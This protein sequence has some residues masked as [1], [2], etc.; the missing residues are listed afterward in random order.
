MVPEPTLR[1]EFPAPEESIISEIE[2]EGFRPSNPLITDLSTLLLIQ[3]VPLE[4]TSLERQFIRRVVMEANIATFLGS[5][6]TPFATTMGGGIVPRPPPSPIRSIAIPTPMT[7]G[8]GSVP[9]IVPTIVLFTQNVTD[10]PF[11]YGM[12]E[13]DTNSV[14]TYSTLQTMGL[15]VGISKSPLQGST[16]GTNVAFNG[17]PYGG[18]HMPP[19]SPSLSGAF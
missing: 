1:G 3:I 5:P 15:G 11:S 9:L 4:V 13:F 16:M 7:L 2:I 18:G 10:T 17:I 14:L 12:P 8:N 19:P 6:R